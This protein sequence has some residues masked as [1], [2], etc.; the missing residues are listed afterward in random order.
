MD[1]HPPST[2]FH[3]MHTRTHT[4]RTYRTVR[5]KERE[6]IMI[7]LTVRR[8][9]GSEHFATDRSEM[10]CLGRGAFEGGSMILG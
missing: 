5:R 6:V 9:V 7:T 1:R 4:V 2:C 10:T 8:V 3:G